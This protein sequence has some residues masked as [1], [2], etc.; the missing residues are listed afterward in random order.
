MLDDA[1][2]AAFLADRF[3]GD[4]G[5]V[6]PVGQGE[7]SKAYTF[8]RAG[9]EYVIRFSALREDFA[10]D[11]L[12][13]RYASRDLPIPRV[14]ELGEAFGG[15][16]AISERMPGGYLDELDEV[17][18]RAILPSLF[19][20]LDAARHVDLSAST[21]YG[22]WDADRTAPHTSWRAALLDVAIDRPTDRTHGWRKRLASSP[23]GSGPFDKAL[24]RLQ[25]LVDACPDERHLLHCD[26][27][28]YNVLV[29]G[30]RISAVIDW[31]CSTYGD[32]LYDLAWFLYWWP[33]YP[34]WHAIDFRSEAVRHYRS[35]GLD[36]P[37]LE[38]RLRCYE[39]H[40]G[41][42]AQA[43]SAFTG[44]WADLEATARRT[45]EI[46]NSRF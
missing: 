31:G 43:Y 13:A 3:H 24:A 35:I 25:S 46:A 26:L 33:W 42:D 2:A 4:A 5:A 17:R 15:F 1:L 39:V 23:T 22:A 34:A 12:A 41:L 10:K 6:S 40:I 18:M 7:W 29:L 19:A 45:L 32:F 11:R 30:D 44:R 36:V 38:E 37:H 27:L 14:I 21:G 16:Y 8:C 20:A 28:H 9:A